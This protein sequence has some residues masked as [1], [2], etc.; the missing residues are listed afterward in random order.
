MRGKL[1]SPFNE[2]EMVLLRNLLPAIA[3]KDLDRFTILPNHIDGLSVLGE[4]YTQSNDKINEIAAKYIESKEGAP[5]TEL[6]I[7]S[8]GKILCGMS[9]HQWNS[10][11]NEVLI[12]ALPQIVQAECKITQSDVAVELKNKFDEIVTEF[13]IFDLG[14]ISSYTLPDVHSVDFRELPGA[15]VM[16]LGNLTAYPA[17]QLAHLN[18]QAASM[19]SVTAIKD[20]AEVDLLTAI[21]RA[22]GEDAKL[23]S[24]L[25]EKL[26]AE[27]GQY[28]PPISQPSDDREGKGEHDHHHHSHSPQL[29]LSLVLLLSSLVLWRILY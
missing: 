28:P 7:K 29:H 10:I 12:N 2:G 9:E 11:E 20:L 17:E 13:N 22:S 3:K 8:L 4:V 26:V 15:A 5:L 16:N 18:P 23:R 24:L 19:L 25:T 27:L 21:A 1:S 6:E 14:W